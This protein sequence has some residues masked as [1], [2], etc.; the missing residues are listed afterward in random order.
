M[1]PELGK[2]ADTVLS[3]YAVS[4]V[5]IAALV[6]WSMWRA[7]RVRA[8]LEEVTARFDN[9]ALADQLERICMDGWSKMPIY[10]RPTLG[11]CLQQRITPRF[12]Y[13]CVASWYVYARHVAKG[14]MPIAYHDPYWDVLEPL[15]QPGQAEAFARTQALWADLP[16]AFESFVPDL[17][18]AIK[19]MDGKWPA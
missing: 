4:L 13:D 5:L 14:R 2:Y 6:A 11:A 8:D 16:H 9:R 12:G 10:I 7:R 17:V 15:L 3:A 19:E 1:M 18:R